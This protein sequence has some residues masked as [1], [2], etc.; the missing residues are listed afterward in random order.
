VDETAAE[1][2]A[3]HLGW[4]EEQAGR[5][6]EDFRKYVERYRPKDFREGVPAGV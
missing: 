2:A 5:E 6:V 3:K 1:V 4:T